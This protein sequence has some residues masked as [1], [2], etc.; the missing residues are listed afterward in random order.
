MKIK[1]AQHSYILPSNCIV[2]RIAMEKAVYLMSG[3]IDS[4]VAAYLG[5]MKGWKPVFVYF[6]NAPYTGNDTKARAIRTVRRVIEVTGE[7]GEML[8]V[9]HGK[10]LESIVSR[11]KN[12][13]YC[14][15]CKRMMYRKADQIAKLFSCGALV[16]GEILGEQASQTMRNLVVD[17]AIIKI[18]ILRPLIGMNKLEVEEIAKRIG[19][20]EISTSNAQGCTANAIKARTRVKSEEVEREEEKLQIKEFVDEA[21]KGLIRFDLC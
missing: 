14:L 20:F 2:K 4:P 11:C 19:T 5:I 17:T 9:P 15:L 3:G 7:K 21:I 1:A 16:T 8:V 12:N 10:D 13:L 18:P 6:D